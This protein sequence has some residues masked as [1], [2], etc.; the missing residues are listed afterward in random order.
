MASQ[1]EIE[2]FDGL[3]AALRRLDFA[4]EKKLLKSAVERGAGP[5]LARA[6]MLCPVDTGKLRESLRLD[7]KAIRGQGVEAV[8]VCGGAAFT[9]P[10]FYGMMVE[11]GHVLGPRVKGRFKGTND[12]RLAAAAAS[13]RKIVPPHPFIRPAF[14][15]NKESA[16]AIAI[17]V[18]GDGLAR[19]WG[20]K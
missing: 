2:G 20:K 11:Y 4:V 10:T 8:V 14:D 16:A 18:I 15:E 19:E 12:E 7:V 3:I 17:K 5:V 9:G 13:G 6:K 1:I